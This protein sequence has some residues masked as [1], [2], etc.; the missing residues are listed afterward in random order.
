MQRGLD[1]GLGARGVDYR[2]GAAVEG[3]VRG[4]D[5]VAG[6][7][8]GGH[9]LREV[10]V[11]GGEGGR[12]VELGLHNVHGDDLGGAVG[13]GDGAAEEPDGAGAHD[14]DGLAGLDAR[15]L[16]YVDC[17]GEGLDEGAFLEGDGGGELVAEVCGGGPEAGEGAVVRGGG[18]EAHVR[19]EVVVAR[20]A[21]GAAAAGVAGLEGDAVAG[22]EGGDGVADGDDGAGGFVA[23]DH[24]VPDDEVADCAVDP[25]VHVGAADAGVVYLDEDI[26]GGLDGGDGLVDEGDVVGP[27]ELEGEVLWGAG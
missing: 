8:L 4:G 13:A 7:F 21:G 11:C 3:Q 14:D 6:V 24:G 27:V 1:G 18:G 19:A 5:E 12:E 25:V 22:L 16:G 26:V 23:E 17:Y 15:L 9:A 20:E 2:V 10:G